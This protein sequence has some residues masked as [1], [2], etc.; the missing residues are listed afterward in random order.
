MKKCTVVASLEFDFRGERFSPGITIDLNRLMLRQGDLNGLHDMLAESIGLDAYRHEY[1][2]MVLEDIT[3]S[4]PTGLACKFVH[5]GH[6]N[7]DGFIQTWEREQILAAIRPIAAK[8]LDIDDL[9]KH[10]AIEKALIESYRT[11]Q[12][13]RASVKR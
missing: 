6:L 7:F 2:V 10:E 9:T 4:E 5:E 3:F 1:D 13:D 12:K 11:G 8:H